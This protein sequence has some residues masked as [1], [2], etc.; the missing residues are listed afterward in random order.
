MVLSF[1]RWTSFSGLSSTMTISFEVRPLTRMRRPSAS[2]Q[3]LSR[4]PAAT[5]I[6]MC[7]RRRGISGRV[8]VSLAGQR[9]SV[10]SVL[11]HSPDRRASAAA[12]TG[13]TVRVVNRMSPLGVVFGVNGG[14]GSGRIGSGSPAAHSST[15]LSAWASGTGSAFR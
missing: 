2:R 15:M 9:V 4:K 12:A 11:V 5:S 7:P 3:R 13:S 8:R 10:I 6:A 1:S 14:Y